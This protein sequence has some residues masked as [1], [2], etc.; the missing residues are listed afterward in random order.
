[1]NSI[2]KFSGFLAVIVV[3]T[4]PASAGPEFRGPLPPEQRDI[5]HFLAGHHDQIERKVT[6]I[7]D[8]YRALTT[9][10]NKKVVKSLKEHVA[11]MEKRLDSGA[12]VRR[13]D[14]AFAEMAAY[15]DQLESQIRIKPNGIEVT[16]TGTTPEAVKVARNHARI[17]SGFAGEGFPAL[18]R[19]HAP[20]L[21]KN[22]SS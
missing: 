4:V 14:P 11:Y 20:A 2:K 13:W 12:M 7:E 21:K 22:K 3:A 1:M 18:Q 5:I 6:V 16:V 10:R 19:E 9:S 8:G 17:V 15:W